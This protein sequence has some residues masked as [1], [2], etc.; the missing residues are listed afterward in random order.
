MY[1]I[2]KSFIFIKGPKTVNTNLCT[3]YYYWGGGVRG[4]NGEKNRSVKVSL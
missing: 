1:R 4:G 2:V 3:N